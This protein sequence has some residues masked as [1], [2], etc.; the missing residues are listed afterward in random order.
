MVANLFAECS[1]TF[2]TSV[3]MTSGTLVAADRAGTC[4][5]A[6]TRKTIRGG[7]DGPVGEAQRKVASGKRFEAAVKANGGTIQLCG[8]NAAEFWSKLRDQE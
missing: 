1:S 7:G 4:R 2:C 5:P 6:G 3:A 8:G